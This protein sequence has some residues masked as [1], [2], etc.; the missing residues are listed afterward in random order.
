MHVTFRF[1]LSLPCKKQEGCTGTNKHG[2]IWDSCKT[3]QDFILCLSYLN[4]YLL[5]VLS[6]VLGQVAAAFLHKSISSSQKSWTC[7]STWDTRLQ[8]FPPTDGK[9]VIASFRWASNQLCSCTEKCHPRLQP[10]RSAHE[11]GLVVVD[12]HKIGGKVSPHFSFMPGM[13]LK[14]SPCGCPNFIKAMPYPVVQ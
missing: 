11:N 14:A 12:G 8:V 4:L 1:S 13:M 10:L 7:E 5:L 9:V 3:W 6:P 2:N